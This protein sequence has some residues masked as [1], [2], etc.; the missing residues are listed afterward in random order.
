M[1]SRETLRLISLCSAMLL[2]SGCVKA[3]SIKWRPPPPRG[4]IA[5]TC[6][7]PVFDP[8]S[9]VLITA[10]SQFHNQF[11]SGLFTNSRLSYVA[12]RVA[13][14]PPALNLWND[15]LL[16]SFVQELYKE[17]QPASGAPRPA[18]MFFLGD[19][20]D[21][22]CTDEY[23]RFEKVMQDFSNSTITA[24]DGAAGA[25]QQRSTFTW[26]MVHGNHDSYMMGNLN[27]YG[28]TDDNR[29]I[30]RLA[31]GEY[32]SGESMD[33]GLNGAQR[34]SRALNRW[35]RSWAG[36][37]AHPTRDSIP[38]NKGVWLRSYLKSLGAQV[39]YFV[40]LAG[41]AQP[42][43][44]APTRH[45]P[46]DASVCLPPRALSGQPRPDTELAHRDYFLTGRVYSRRRLAGE[47]R[48]PAVDALPVPIIN[49]YNSF[50]VQSLDID[51]DVR[52]ILIDTSQ[53]PRLIGP[54]SITSAAGS[55]GNIDDEQMKEIF[56]HA[57][58]ARSK[59][60]RISFFAHNPLTDLPK[61]QQK[62]LLS[63]NPIAYVSGHTHF[64]SSVIRH[65]VGGGDLLELN[66]GSTADWPMEAM[67]LS[68]KPQ[69][70]DWRVYGVREPAEVSG[71]I[72]GAPACNYKQ[73]SWAPQRR[74]C[75]EFGLRSDYLDYAKKGGPM[76]TH[77]LC[78]L[79]TELRTVVGSMPDS[80]VKPEELCGIRAEL[81]ESTNWIPTAAE[82]SVAV[83]RWRQAAR[84][85]G[86]VRALALCQ[87][88]AASRA[89]N[90]NR[91]FTD[92]V[93]ERSANV[94]PAASYTT[95]AVGPAQK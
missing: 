54:G 94:S 88:I 68:V 33:Y 64:E 27:A 4:S 10:D 43:E 32:T 67:I 29:I 40:T 75:E 3:L 65:K 7:Q 69:K 38:M 95:A 48:C 21:I 84:E 81:V 22:S 26:L 86:V 25:P 31:E 61:R 63:L 56:R 15:V 66:V 45:G 90:T 16:Y 5:L 80:F 6:E 78:A 49:P 59:G 37:C 89:A 41:E 76:I 91:G 77:D 34:C 73:V 14:R 2:G 1:I 83:D 24:T 8:E 20:G 30:D 62:I 35:A 70:V 39:Q 93:P 42:R 74:V 44:S 85:P 50:I 82:M 17:V 46:L 55:V 23:Q 51:K 58:Y 53:I 71:S 57:E 9:S 72:A 60:K 12:T 19:A 92:A 52:A 28:R 18:L 11:G 87:G 36:A 13:I 47:S 79:Q